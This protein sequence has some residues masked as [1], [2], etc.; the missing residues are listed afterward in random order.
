MS[1]YGNTASSFKR[2]V[3]SGDCVVKNM[4]LVLLFS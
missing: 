4:D 2:S 1:E 3:S